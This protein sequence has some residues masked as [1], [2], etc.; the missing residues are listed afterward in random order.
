MYLSRQFYTGLLVGCFLTVL[1]MSGVQHFFPRHPAPSQNL[2]AEHTIEDPTTKAT[3]SSAPLLPLT[4]LASPTVSPPVVSP[5]AKSSSTL[6]TPSPALPV[7]MVT[8]KVGL[9]EQPA[10]VASATPKK[11]PSHPSRTR[12]VTPSSLASCAVFASVLSSSVIETLSLGE[13][14]PASLFSRTLPQA[15]LSPSFPLPKTVSAATSAKDAKTGMMFKSTPNKFSFHRL[16]TGEGPTLLVVGGI[17]G[18]E[19]GG[20]SAAALLSTHYS[21]THG[22]LW[23]IPD[24]NYASI[25][26][27]NRGLF[28]DMNRKFAHLDA[29]DPEY[30]LVQGI[31]QVLL[32]EEVDLILNL[33]DGSGFYSPTWV[34]KMRNPNRWGQS[35]IIDKQ[36]MDAPRFNKLH[37]MAQRAEQD[38]NTALVH[39]DHRYG[40]RNTNTHL[41]DK[42][43]EKSLSWFAV[44]NGKP[45]FGI[46]ASKEFTTEYRSYYHMLIVESFMRQMGIAFERTIP[47]SP[48]SVLVALNSNLTLSLY[49]G[50]IVLPLDDV[51]PTLN[52]IPFALHDDPVHHASRPLVSILPET[53]HRWRV[54]YGNRT[55]TRLQ[56]EKMPFD[57]SLTGVTMTV[58]GKRMPIRFGKIVPVRKDF[59]VHHKDGYRV[60]AIGATCEVNGTEADVIIT[61]KDFMPRFSVDKKALLYRLEVYKDDAFCGMILVDFGTAY[62]PENSNIPLTAVKGEESELGY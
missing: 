16:G 59:M 30:E 21:I 47:L 3:T 62:H 17:Q 25:V 4:P 9:K 51:R 61:Q 46:E 50:K 6:T 49:D 1:L 14:S 35:V 55:L 38:A 10:T 12:S 43:M 26:Q 36:E 41:G 15:K 29:N 23:V 31:K 53:D 57:S 44:L 52:N 20:F 28:G 34:N 58:D 22:N 48:K 45:A 54:A 7:A 40:I 33:H 27:R 32:A 13:D 56:P 60:N 37:H 19:P 39:P 11:A 2:L 5:P 18:D 42:E 8:P 24:L